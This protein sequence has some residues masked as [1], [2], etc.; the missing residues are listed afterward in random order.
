MKRISTATVAPPN[1]NTMATA[2]TAVPRVM[3][4]SL[5]E[6]ETKLNRVRYVFQLE[7]FVLAEMNI[8]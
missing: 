5:L 7:S 6:S 2:P 3:G 4:I 1:R 8:N